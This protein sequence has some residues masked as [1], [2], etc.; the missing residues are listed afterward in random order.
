MTHGE[1][2]QGSLDKVGLSIRDPKWRS[3]MACFQGVPRCYTMDLMKLILMEMPKM[4][5]AM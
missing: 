4:E 3:R 5:V 2:C 1:Y